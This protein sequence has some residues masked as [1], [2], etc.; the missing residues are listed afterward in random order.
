MPLHPLFLTKCSPTS[1]LL[2]SCAVGIFLPP[3]EE[4]PKVFLAQIITGKKQVVDKRL[5]PRLSAPK[6]PEL[7]L[8]EIWE[9]VKGDEQLMQYF[10]QRSPLDTKLPNRDFFWGVMFSVRLNYSEELVAEAR[11]KRSQ[12]HVIKPMANTLL[13]VGITR[14]WCDVLL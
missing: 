10:P 13:N 3:F 6:W 5:V 1:S 4:C 8:K 11:R 12:R 14:Q 7:S 2:V 9:R